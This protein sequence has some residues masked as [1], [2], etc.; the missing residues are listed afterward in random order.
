M[1]SA[2]KPHESDPNAHSN[3]TNTYT[4]SGGVAYAP[5]SCF[6]CWAELR[7]S[8]ECE[9]MD[10]PTCRRCTRDG[11]VTDTI[12]GGFA[13]PHCC[14][15][16]TKLETP[17]RSY[18]SGLIINN[19]ALYTFVPAGQTRSLGDLSASYPKARGTRVPAHA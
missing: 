3:F 19:E 18:K 17:F 13:P 8:E 1:L 10:V 6:L 9:H 14:T 15:M 4:K 5:D 2:A 12:P 7:C 11:F 16:Q